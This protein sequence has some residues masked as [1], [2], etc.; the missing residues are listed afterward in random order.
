M[1]GWGLM[2]DW[3]SGLEFSC[4]VVLCCVVLLKELNTLLFL[5]LMSLVLVIT[6]ELQVSATLYTGK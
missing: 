4:C 6:F 1:E 3:F 5:N 2:I